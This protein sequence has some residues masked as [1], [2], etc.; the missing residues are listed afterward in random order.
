MIW[1][2]LGPIHGMA[3]LPWAGAGARLG[4]GHVALPAPPE[5]PPLDTTP[6]TTD[7]SVALY[8][9]YSDGQELLQANQSNF[10]EHL[11]S[12]LL[13]TALLRDRWHLYELKQV[14]CL[15][16]LNSTRCVYSKSLLWN[17]SRADSF[18]C[19]FIDCGCVAFLFLCRS[20]D[21]ETSAE[22]TQGFCFCQMTEHNAA[23]QQR[24]DRVGQEV[25]HRYNIK[26]SR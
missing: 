3:R 2:L 12:W 25:R 14:T 26:T 13:Y 17:G 22:E 20:S 5:A 6:S 15:K 10:R 24:A 23:I 11:F 21:L 4:R 16:L 1:A 19:A 8:A 7:L 18:Q 9:L